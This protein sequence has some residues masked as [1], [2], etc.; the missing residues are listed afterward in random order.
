MY[1]HPVLLFFFLSSYYRAYAVYDYNTLWLNSSPIYLSICSLDIFYFW[2]FLCQLICSR[3]LSLE[4]LNIR[5][6]K[7]N[8]TFNS[9]ACLS[10]IPWSLYLFSVYIR[11]VF[12]SLLQYW[13]K[14][15][16]TFSNLLV[17]RTFLFFLLRILCILGSSV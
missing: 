8:P 13:I 2:Y 14:R 7:R 5:N 1:L 4:T 12:P 11:I 10:A 3:P 6:I 17:F 9:V 15:K 16:E